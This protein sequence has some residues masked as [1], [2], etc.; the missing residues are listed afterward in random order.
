[1]KLFVVLAEHHGRIAGDRAAAWRS[2]LLDVCIAQVAS[3]A[4]C[5]VLAS[6]VLFSAKLAVAEGPPL[7]GVDGSGASATETGKSIP[8]HMRSYFLAVEKLRR[9][10]HDKAPSKALSHLLK[11][12]RCA[13][14]QGSNRFA[15]L[16]YKQALELH[17]RQPPSVQGRYSILS[18]LTHVLDDRPAEALPYL[19]ESVEL[20]ETQG[21]PSDRYTPFKLG[22]AYRGLAVALSKLGRTAEAK[23]AARTSL[24]HSGKFVMPG[25]VKKKK[26]AKP[27][28]F[29]GA[30]LQAQELAWSSLDKPLRRILGENV[31]PDD[32]VN[33]FGLMGEVEVASRQG[34]VDVGLNVLGL[35]AGALHAGIAA[36]APVGSTGVGALFPNMLSKLEASGEALLFSA[37][38]ERVESVGDL[39]S[40]LFYLA[41]ER[42]GRHYD[43]A[44]RATTGATT[45]Q[46]SP[47]VL[48]ARRA[49]S[50]RAARYLRRLVQEGEQEEARKDWCATTMGTENETTKEAE[51]QYRLELDAYQGGLHGKRG[52]LMAHQGIRLVAASPRSAMP[53]AKH[54][55]LFGDIRAALGATDALV[56]FVKVPV[57]VPGVMDKGLPSAPVLAAEQYVAYVVRKGQ[58]LERVA[59]APANVIDRRVKLW[60]Q[61]VKNGPE[62]DL[63]AL[64]RLAAELGDV[65]FGRLGSSLHGVRRVFVVG[66][67]QLQYFPLA[68]LEV[69][70]QALV[71]RYEFSY[72]N[73]ARTL[74][75][76]AVDQGSVVSVTSASRAK[77]REAV[78]F[79][80]PDVGRN[81]DWLTPEKLSELTGVPREADIVAGLLGRYAVRRI[82]G[83]SASEQALLELRA[84]SVL[85]FGGHGVFIPRGYLG[86]RK[87]EE[88]GARLPLRGAGGEVDIEV[89]SES[90]QALP[91]IDTPLM[92]T[93]LLTAVPATLGTGPYDGVATSYEIARMDL[94]GTELV[95]LGACD[96]A[97]GI[98]VG[99][100]GV[101]SLRQAFMMAGAKTVV[102]SLWPVSDLP[103]VM[104]MTEFYQQILAGAARGVAMHRAMAKVRRKYPHPAHWAAFTISGETGPMPLPTRARVVD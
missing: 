90:P 51:S 69:D 96:T 83:R 65:L 55:E 34:K 92:H 4:I 8:P 93:A 79:E 27:K 95:V 70:G 67:G 37:Q 45:D 11:Q 73:S 46:W 41:V 71:E 58:G 5:L 20:L 85:H 91:T 64:D 88:S 17:A 49:R 104:M 48:Q 9:R 24:A 40:L 25:M 53:R 28:S 18:Q 38:E 33:V 78:V 98:D 39:E 42:Q 7:L 47:K 57:K 35:A 6:P 103:T 86:P 50:R 3:S 97:N 68:A 100:Q 23:E 14:R 54:R 75:G 94:R 21:R 2:V 19:L 89:P 102:A 43:V 52:V 30:A 82:S 44:A 63:V 66:D 72:L 76:M 60:L 81:F 10:A 22:V 56:N 32:P 36:L 84:P 74:L 1:M 101:S 12:A 80:V 26:G 62:A 59:L 99:S 87:R 61:G 16:L 29:L 13:G 31:P 15:A 77:G